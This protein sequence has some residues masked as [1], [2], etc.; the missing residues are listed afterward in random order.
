MIWLTVDDVH[1]FQ[2]MFS[3][4]H[5]NDALQ[6]RVLTHNPTHAIGTNHKLKQNTQTSITS[7]MLPFLRSIDV[8]AAFGEEVCQQTN[9]TAKE[10][11]VVPANRLLS[12]SVKL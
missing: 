2:D 5:Q 8:H 3:T 6:R 10:A 12:R 4:L 7:S 11:K 1:V 9:T